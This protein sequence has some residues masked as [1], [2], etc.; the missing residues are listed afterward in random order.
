MRLKSGLVS[1]AVVALVA[2]CG[3]KVHTTAAQDGTGG[4]AGNG[5]GG[6]GGTDTGGTGGT[7]GGTSAPCDLSLIASG[8]LPQRGQRTVESVA[9]A[10]SSKSYTVAYVE[11]SPADNTSRNTTILK[12]RDAGQLDGVERND[13]P[14]CPAGT[15]LGAAAAFGTTGS[16]GLAAFAAQGCQ[17]SGSGAMFFHLTDSAGPG[18]PKLALTPAF[19]ALSLGP[20][21]LAPLDTDRF[22]FVYLPTTKPAGGAQMATLTG[23]AFDGNAVELF[24]A[25]P[26]DAA[27]VATSS[28]VQAILG[29]LGSGAEVLQ[30]GAPDADAGAPMVTLGAQPWGAVTTIGNRVAVLLPTATGLEYRLFDSNQ[31]V[32]K[33]ALSDTPTPHGDITV[34]GDRLIA[35]GAGAGAMTLYRVDHANATPGAAVKVPVNLPALSP[36]QIAIAAAR[37]TVAVV[38]TGKGSRGHWALFSCKG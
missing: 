28:S 13:M 9:V 4:T 18:S 2:G 33:Q 21:A 10:A 29:H 15:S 35:V 5:S 7:G 12:L 38:Y 36:G 27:A 19:S 26:A 22:A 32:H 25:Q 8:A 16:P 30:I 17:G 1:A 31:Q 20:H 6:S 24:G 34:L 37:N 3:G 23:T 14:V 11:Q